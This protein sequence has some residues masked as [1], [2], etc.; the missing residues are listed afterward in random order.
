MIV[1]FLQYA[2]IRFYFNGLLNFCAFDWKDSA[3]IFREE[4]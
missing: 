2:N 4:G 1:L 3:F